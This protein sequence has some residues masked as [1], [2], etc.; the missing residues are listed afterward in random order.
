MAEGSR[1]PDGLELVPAWRDHLSDQDRAVVLAAGYGRQVQAG[2]HPALVLVD[3]QYAYV[4]DDRPIVEQLSAWPSAGGAAAWQA[5]RT[6]LPVLERA[7]ASEIPVFL[8]RIGYPASEAERNPFARKRGNGT[9]F[10]LGSRG[11]E[12]VEELGRDD[13]DVLVTKTAAS[14]FYGTDFDDQLRQRGVDTL[15][16]T[17][18]STS[19][20]VRATVVD[21]AARG[22]QVIVLGDCVADRI[23][24]SHDL[25]LFDVW[26]KYGSVW[27]A[28]EGSNY[29]SGLQAPSVP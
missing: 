15:V 25:T 1:V 8:S 29:L 6:T 28:A 20:C 16:V 22:Y 12:L 27:S 9:G 23:T 19:G 2:S 14:M 17:G 3:F 11:T 21:A 26:L 7:R 24:A 4:G 10:V 18:L 5:L 13:G